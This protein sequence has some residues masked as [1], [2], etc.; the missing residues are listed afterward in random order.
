MIRHLKNTYAS[1]DGVPVIAAV[2]PAIFSKRYFTD[3][4]ACTFCHDI[5]CSYGAD[6]DVENFQRL[7]PYADALEDFTH[8]PRAEWL[9]GQ[10]E[11]DAEVAGG[12]YTRTRV[13]DGRCAFLNRNGRGCLIHRFCLEKGLDYH[14]LKPVVCWLFPVTF[15]NGLLGPS[16]EIQDN[17]LICMNMGPTLYRAARGELHYYFGEGLVAELDQLESLTQTVR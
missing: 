12:R 10:F 4:L 15:D 6:I 13:R 8:V 14:R 5:C 16:T 3:C 7:E 2:D 11:D 17:S 9:T 1:R